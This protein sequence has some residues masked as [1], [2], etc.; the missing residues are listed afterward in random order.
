MRAVEVSQ[1]GIPVELTPE[2]AGS[3][4]RMIWD[5][6]QTLEARATGLEASVTQAINSGKRLVGL[7]LEGTIG[8]EAWTATVPEV[9][10]LGEAMGVNVAKPAI[11][12]PKQAIKAGLPED[13]VKAF[14][15]RKSGAVKLVLSNDRAVRQAFQQQE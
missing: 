11:L 6:I 3:E 15:A 12:T 4:L 10:S 13:V 2:A 7:G 14:S 9:L 8:R 5:A 1:R